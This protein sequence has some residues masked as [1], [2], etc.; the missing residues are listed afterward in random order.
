MNLLSLQVFVFI[1]LSTHPTQVS[2][3]TLGWLTLVY[4]A[5]TILL[6]DETRYH[7]LRDR[8]QTVVADVAAN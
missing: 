3:T 6:R 7:R 8:H 5:I 4:I 2:E 1:L